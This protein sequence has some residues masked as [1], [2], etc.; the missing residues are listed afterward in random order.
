MGLVYLKFRKFECNKIQLAK[1]SYHLT[2]LTECKV[3]E[4]VPKGIMLKVP[5]HIRRFI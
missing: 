3:H 1:T 2:F 4:I 5:Y